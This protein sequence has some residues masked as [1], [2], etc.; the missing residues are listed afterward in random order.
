MII[1]EVEKTHAPRKNKEI[2]PLRKSAQGLGVFLKGLSDAVQSTKKRKDD[3]A[4]TL[5]TPYTG[6]SRSFKLSSARD[7]SQISS[8]LP[9]KLNFNEEQT[10]A[11]SLLK[12]ARTLAADASLSR[13]SDSERNAFAARFQTIFQ[14]FGEKYPKTLASLQEE[15][16][17]T[18]EAQLSVSTHQAAAIAFLNIEDMIV[19]IFEIGARQHDGQ[20]SAKNANPQQSDLKTALS[21]SNQ[22]KELFMTEGG[23]KTFGRFQEIDRTNVLGLLK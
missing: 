11:L 15:E 1:R 7:E 17:K 12:E 6:A 22:I 10:H 21:A 14:E 23:A 19:K 2:N 13:L 3:D 18:Q 5:E 8:P 16:K 4:D 9:F 20:S